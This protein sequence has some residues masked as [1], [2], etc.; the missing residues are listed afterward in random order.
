MLLSSQLNESLFLS[1]S[2]VVVG[3]IYVYTFMCQLTLIYNINVTII[4]TNPY[5]F[6]YSDVFVQCCRN[7]SKR[8]H[9]RQV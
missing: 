2:H 8:R 1:L 7:M 9:Y 4:L 3:T 6:V 5:N